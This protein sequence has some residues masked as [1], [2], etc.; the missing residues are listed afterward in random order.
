[1]AG[2]RQQGA[3]L[4]SPAIYR[5]ANLTSLATSAAA[6]A[7]ALT[8]Y[9]HALSGGLNTLPFETKEEDREVYRFPQGD[10]PATLMDLSM[11]FCPQWETVRCGRAGPKLQGR[12]RN[13]DQNAH[14]AEDWL[15]PGQL[16][17]AR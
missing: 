6:E 7:D 15:V 10:I 8:K 5:P 17:A 12:R 11:A 16:Q 9:L 4:I 1:M 13:T 2:Q 14:E 3:Q